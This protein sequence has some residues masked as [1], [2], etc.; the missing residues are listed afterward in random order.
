MAVAGCELDVLFVD[1][2]LVAVPVVCAD[3]TP[4]DSA[5]TDIVS[6]V[7][8]IYFFSSYEEVPRGG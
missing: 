5:R 4:S 7:F 8:F 1:V 2:P 6:H 3:A